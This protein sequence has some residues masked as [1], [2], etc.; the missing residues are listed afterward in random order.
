ES[1]CARLVLSA[2]RRSA[3]PARTTAAKSA[4]DTLVTSPSRERPAAGTVANQLRVMPPWR[5][6]TAIGYAWRPLSETA[7]PPER[8][9]DQ[10]LVMGPATLPGAWVASTKLSRGR[11]RLQGMRPPRWAT[12][13][14]SQPIRAGLARRRGCPR[15]RAS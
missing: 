14:R 10:E 7:L 8:A 4:V 6:G 13:D 2:R 11:H 12:R 9:R 3:R 1:C 15:D 5:I